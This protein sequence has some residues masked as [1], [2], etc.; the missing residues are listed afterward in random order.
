MLFTCVQPVAP[1]IT[2]PGPIPH[3]NEGYFFI[4][5][6]WITS[7]TWGPSL[8]CKQTLNER[9]ERMRWSHDQLWWN[10]L[11][12]EL[13]FSQA[14]QWKNIFAT[15]TSP[16]MHL[17]CSPKFCITFVFYFFW[18]LQPSQ[19]KLKTILLMQNFGGQIRCIM[20][21]V[22]MENGGQCGE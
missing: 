9:R 15:C 14:L 16:M 5:P 22:Q 17:I 10:L 3:V 18:V 13:I 21:D 12:F 11:M 19:E 8:P 6:K 7:P 2:F 4:S 1:S 20:G